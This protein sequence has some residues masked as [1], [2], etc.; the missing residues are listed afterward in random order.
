MKIVL[1]T[2]GSGG[3]LFPAL[4]VA[5]EF[6]NSGH[7]I[8][9]LGSFNKGIEQINARGFKFKNHHAQGLSFINPKRF[10]LSGISIIKAFFISCHVLR[11]IRPDAVAGFGCYG[12][13]P[14]VLAAVI[15]RCPA[16]IHEQNVVPGKANIFLSVFVKKIAI[17]FPQSTEYFNPKKAILTGCPCNFSGMQADKNK[18]LKAFHLEYERKTILVVGGS[19]GSHRINKEFIHVVKFL[20]GHNLQVIHICGKKDYPWLNREYSKSGIPVAL[21]EFLDK[22]KDAYS[23]ADLVIS[24][25]GAATISEIIIAGSPSILIPYPYAGGHQKKN[26]MVLSSAGG[27]EIIEETVLSA[28]R[29]EK[30]IFKLMANQL[31][32][33][34]IRGKFKDISFPD[35]ANRLAKEIVNLVK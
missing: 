27:A 18:I 24:R 5:E 32:R 35:A 13:F 10:F 33:E 21:F 8:F 3:H 12:A 9:I 14:V 23:V 19:Q 16:L 26:A 34:E 30:V 4:K 29:L 6:E 31:S 28:S 15:L 11:K 1:G 2:G 22:I 17:S 25:S 20:K 7:E